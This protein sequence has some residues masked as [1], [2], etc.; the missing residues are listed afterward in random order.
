MKQSPLHQ[1]HLEEGGKLVPFAGW[2]MPIQYAGI[3]AE[4]NAVRDAVGV[5]DISHMGEILVSGEGAEEGL[6]RVLTNQVSRLSDGEGQYTL[7]LQENGG[8][9][10]DLILYRL[11]EDSFF[12]VV[13]ASRVE[14]DYEWL[15]K[16]LG[17]DIEVRNESDAWGALAVQG[18]GTGDLWE[19]ISP[20]V[21]LPER[22]GILRPRE[23]LIL[24]RTGYT[25]EDGFELFAPAAQIESWWDRIREA[26]ATACG[27][28]ARDT[29]RLEKGYPLN[30]NDLD[31]IHT[32]LEAGLG[33]FVDLEK[34]G[35]F[36]GSEKLIEQKAS[37]PTH[38]LVALRMTKKGPPPRHGYE[39]RDETGEI[40][41]GTLSSGSLSPTLG[42]GIGMAY[43]E[44][45]YAKV[46]T[47]LSMMIR[48]RRYPIEVIKKPF[49]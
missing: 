10:D 6:N 44:T 26:G 16:H 36:I 49:C 34:D 33:F 25:G 31:R 37:G 11:A 35:G 28:G 23:D 39:V 47:S 12:L 8:V 17:G 32:P 20:S 5:F 21:S 45:R 42:Q 43:L 1:R 27:L 14:E 46:G 13:N 30:G 24:C 7:M 41:I 2:E 15:T 3:V 19:K 4:H 38:R 29:L 48:D 9:I 40:S 22:N 18:P